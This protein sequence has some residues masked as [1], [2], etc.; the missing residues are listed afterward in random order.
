MLLFLPP[1]GLFFE[2]VGGGVSTTKL[3]TFELVLPY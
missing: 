2:T 1:D 3:A